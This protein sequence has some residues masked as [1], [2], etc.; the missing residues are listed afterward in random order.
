M[1]KYNFE[2]KCYFFTCSPKEEKMSKWIFLK[3]S[4]NTDFHSVQLQNILTYKDNFF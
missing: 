3:Y 2:N 4:N 1:T